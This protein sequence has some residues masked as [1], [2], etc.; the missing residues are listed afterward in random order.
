MV[1]SFQQRWSDL[2][3][4]HLS[5]SGTASGAKCGAKP[6]PQR[7]LL[8]LPLWS[9][10]STGCC[11]ADNRERVQPVWFLLPALS[12]AKSPAAARASPSLTQLLSQYRNLFLPDMSVPNTK[13]KLPSC[14][15][16]CCFSDLLVASEVLHEFGSGI[17]DSISIHPLAGHGF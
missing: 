1:K 5:V 16:V 17:L 11:T 2:F 13:G 4:A 6:D 15:C 8:W 12:H 3:A 10:V 9:A 14:S 7:G